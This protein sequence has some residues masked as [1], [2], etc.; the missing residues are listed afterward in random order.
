MKIKFTL[1]GLIVV[2]V[3]GPVLGQTTGVSGGG[4]NFKVNCSQKVGGN[5]PSIS[6]A[7]KLLLPAVQNTITVSG[8]CNENV[9]L[10]GFDRLTLITT[11]GATIND[12]SGGQ[13]PVLDIEDSRRVTVQ[14]FNI[15]GG[16][17]GIVCGS[18]SV[19]YITGN[20]VQS[21]AGQEGILI[22]G[23]S[24]GFLLNNMVKNNSQRGMTVNEGGQ[25][26]SSTDTFQNNADTGI[27][28]NTN[29]FLECVSSTV[30]NN[31]NGG[32]VVTDHSTLRSIS[33]A[34]GGNT[35]DGVIVQRGSAARFD[36]YLGATTVSS[37]T[38]NGVFVRDLSS[39]F[40]SPGASITGNQSGTDVVCAPQ[41]PATRGTATNIGGGTTNC[42]E[43]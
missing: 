33:C 15:N 43:P 27:V 38:G 4:I 25:A 6:A 21:S 19:C 7:L 20:T 37:N 2:C 26:F 29:G 17:D 36:S 18:A 30:E 32:I 3:A 31:G 14:G 12:A 16:A 13:L 42:T 5:L 39:G 41:F 34:V 1:A 22:G 11:T 40:F 35:G 9:S 8:A 23:G 24:R 28:L 10:Q